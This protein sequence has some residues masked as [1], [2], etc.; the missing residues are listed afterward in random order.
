MITVPPAFAIATATCEGEAGRTWIAE[1]PRLVEALV[2]EWKLVI[3]G[4]PMHGYLGLVVP[5]RYRAEPCV[6]KISWIDE[7]TADEALALSAW[8]GR[9][10]VRLLRAQLS[11][12][13][14]LL[15]RLDHTR[16]LHDVAIAEA[17]DIAGRLLSRLAIPAPADLRP[18]EAVAE[19]LCR[20]LPE[21]RSAT[22]ARCHDAC[23]IVPATC[24]PSSRCPASDCCRDVGQERD[25]Y[26]I[27]AGE[28]DRV[29]R[30]IR[31][32]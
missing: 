3:D 15:E 31:S 16:S 2:A 6:L 22:A 11:L 9:G 27:S 26:M 8:N 5:V 14:L 29:I 12:G 24:L 4:P 17:V 28:S 30:E 1:L 25:I 19:E 20:I 10:A 32:V 18:L 23:S 21:R 7:S 13:A